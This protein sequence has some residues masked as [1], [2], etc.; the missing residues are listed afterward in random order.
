MLR[1]LPLVLIGLCLHAADDRIKVDN[2]FVRV[3]KAVQEP[4]VIGPMHR[5]EFNR[6][7]IYLDAADLAVTYEDGRKVAE[8]W[9]AGQVAW[10]PIAGMH[11]SE[12]VGSG[13]IRII[14]VE[15]KKP[16]KSAPAARNRALDPVVLD[17]RH[18]VL[19]FENP[20]VRVFRS[21]REPG[22]SEKMHEHAGPGRLAILLTDLHAEVKTADGAVATQ[23][24]AA[25]DVLWSGPVTHTAKNIGP[26]PFQMIVIELR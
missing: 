7:M 2:E 13:P 25:G 15:I 9:K 26:Q 21:W 14:E 8:H 5:H 22:A 6:V 17:P 4:H 20:Q 18:N 23:H 16:A 10:S 19:L 24:A 3:I 12:N 1:L 11:T